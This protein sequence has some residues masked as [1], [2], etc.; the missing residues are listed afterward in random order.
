MWRAV[1][2]KIRPGENRADRQGSVMDGSEVRRP[3]ANPL[4]VF[5]K[6]GDA[7]LE[8]FDG[9]DQYTP[10]PATDGAASN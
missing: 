3:I 2:K 4:L 1:K 6:Q 10:G 9:F 5:P 8:V 7:R